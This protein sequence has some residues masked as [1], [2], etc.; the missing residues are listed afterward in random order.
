MERPFLHSFIVYEMAVRSER[1]RSNRI[2][3]TNYLSK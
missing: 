3:R 2:K 1:N